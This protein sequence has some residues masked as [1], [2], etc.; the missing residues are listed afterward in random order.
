MNGQ[1]QRRHRTLVVMV[2]CEAIAFAFVLAAA[3]PANSLTLWANCLRVGLD[4]PASFFALH[5]SRRILRRQDGGFDYGLGKWENLAS[6]V[7]VPVMFAGLA[8][9]AFRASRNLLDPQP[10]EHTGFG[11][12]VLLVFAVVNIALTLR[13]RRLQGLAPSPLMDAQFVL[14]RNATAAS[15]I[16]LL[17]LGGTFWPGPAGVYFDV[18]GAAIQA[19]FIVHG[20]LLLLRRSLSALLDQAVEESLLRQIRSGLLDVSSDY[21]QLFRIRTRHS[22]NRIFVELFLGFDPDI[23]VRELLERS[24][25]IRRKIEGAVPH[26]EVTIVPQ[27]HQAT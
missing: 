4:L 2:W 5:V 16:S 8:F 21:R 19:L 27:S 15:L 18:A 26:S 17:A 13:F 6:L 7:N 24:T 11:M 20:A 10:V 14:Y 1:E 23:T 22:G 9:L 3:W 12:A 25:R